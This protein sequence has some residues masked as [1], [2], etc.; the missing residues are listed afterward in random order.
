MDFPFK[1]VA[2]F[3]TS[4]G[5]GHAARSCAVMEAIFN[6]SPD[7]HI[8]IYTSIPDWFFCESLTGEYKL[9]PINVDVG[10][11]QSS[12]LTEDLHSTL[13]ALDRTFPF[14]EYFINQVAQQIVDLGCDLVICDISPLG[15]VAAN[16][17]KLPSVLIEN[18]TWDWI[19]EYYS[20]DFPGI[21]KHIEYLRD[22]YSYA[23]LRLQTEPFCDVRNKSGKEISP[24]SR[25]PH[26]D[27]EL[28]RVSLGI[29]AGEKMVL[30]TMG[31]I[32]DMGFVNVDIKLPGYYMVIPGG[33][34]RI[35]KS[36]Q[37]ILLPHHSDFYHPDLVYAADLVVGKAGYST[38][39]EVYCSGVPLGYILRPNFRES[40]PMGTFIR[41]Y[42]R[43]F[44]IN[45][46]EYMNGGWTKK[47][48]LLDGLSRNEP[49]IS[50]GK[51]TVAAIS[52][53]GYILRADR[54]ENRTS[55]I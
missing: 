32:P 48:P 31:G 27:R 18:F 46:V 35:E 51:E 8:D 25:N 34:D 52:K 47:L 23:L 43:G 26:Q 37:M 42:L 30:L 45:I 6:Q 10:I 5:Y 22:I 20:N 2:Y 16:C 14:S 38:I 53:M 12:P 40:G 9:H 7:V 17:A 33:S 1:H 41:N 50:G 29:P 49:R 55:A 13:V 54:N 19:Y 39:A 28:V 24:I 36:E 21:N 15:I 44:E 4:H 3:I 11:V